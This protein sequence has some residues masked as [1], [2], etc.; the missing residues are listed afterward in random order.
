MKI[1]EKKL[2]DYLKTH[3]GENTTT[4]RLVRDSE[5]LEEGMDDLEIDEEVRRIAA[6]NK[7]RLNADHNYF[8]IL[9]L[10]YNIDFY[11][12]EYDEEAVIKRIRNTES[13]TEQLYLIRQEYGIEDDLTGEFI[14]F[15]YDLPD[16]LRKIYEEGKA[17]VDKCKKNGYL[18]D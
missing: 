16:E 8:K 1:N 10:P 12:E 5:A 15:R 14:T 4:W 2:A 3:V 7:F 11:I 17:Y 18:I 13:L 9:G 6:E